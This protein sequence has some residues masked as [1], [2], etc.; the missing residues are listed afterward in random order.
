MTGKGHEQIKQ[1]F[2]S[3]EDHCVVGRAMIQ[4]LKGARHMSVEVRQD[5]RMVSDFVLQIIDL[6]ISIISELKF[7]ELKLHAGQY[8]VK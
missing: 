5:A 1:L 2:A 7:L 8:L 4:E 6:S 3:L